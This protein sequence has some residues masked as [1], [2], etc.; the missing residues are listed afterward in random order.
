MQ[1]SS[2]DSAS[3]LQRQERQGSTARPEACGARCGKTHPSRGGEMT[4][5]LSDSCMLRAAVSGVQRSAILGA[6]AEVMASPVSQ[7]WG[8]AQI[9]FRKHPIVRTVAVGWPPMAAE[10]AAS[11]SGV[12]CRHC[13][14]YTPEFGL[15]W[16]PRT[17]PRQ[18]RS[19]ELRPRSKSC[20]RHSLRSS[21]APD[22]ELQPN[23]Y[24]GQVACPRDSK[25]R[26]SRQ[27]QS[28]VA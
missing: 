24:S 9:Q 21:F 8:I 22:L 5:T 12:A 14:F 23:T 18:L 17:G 19:L 25:V 7:V 4:G 11:V 2:P 28:S 10:I 20:S 13:S 3:G 27:R 16:R 6:G 15:G 26:R 1:V